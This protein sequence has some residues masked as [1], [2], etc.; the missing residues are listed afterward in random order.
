MRLLEWD[1]TQDDCPFKKR[2]LGHRPTQ[3]RCYE[4][5]KKTA[6]YKPTRESAEESKPANSLTLGF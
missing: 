5:R 6:F 3:E 4:D 1:L 2:R